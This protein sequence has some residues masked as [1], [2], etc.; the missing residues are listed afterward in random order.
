MLEFLDKNHWL[1][2]T[3]KFDFLDFFKTYFIWS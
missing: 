3:E 1:T 2:T